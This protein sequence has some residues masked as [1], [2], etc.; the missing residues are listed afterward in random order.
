MRKIVFLS[1][2]INLSSFIGFGQISF[3]K[4]MTDNG[5]D[6]GQGIVQLEDSS[7]IVTGSSSSFIEGPSQAFLLKLDSL[8]NFLWSAHYGGSES[9]WGRRVLNWNDSIFYVTGHSNSSGTGSYNFYLIK[10]DK[11]GNQLLDKHYERDGWDKMNDAAFSSD[12]TIFMVG[13]TTGTT[14]GNSDFYIVKT[15]KDG[16]TLWTKSFGT[17]GDDA[18]NSIKQYDDTTFYCVGKIFNTDS[19]LTKAAVLKLHADGTVIWTKEFGENGNYELND[20]FF[21][22]PYLKAVGT[23][24]HPVDGD[25][26]EYLLSVGLTGVFDVEYNVHSNGDVTYDNVTQYGSSGKIYIASFYKNDFSSGQSFDVGITRFTESLNWDVA[27]VNIGFGL[28]DRSGEIIPTNDGGA[29]SVGYVSGDDLGGSGVYVIKIGPNDAF[30]A[31][32]PNNVSG[33]VT[34][35]EIDFEVDQLIVFP[36]PSNGN[37]T[38][39]T[40]EE[41]LVNIVDMNGKQVHSDSFSEFTEISTL[42]W[43]KGIY[44]LK[45]QTQQ[46]KAGTLKLVVQ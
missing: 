5:Y 15:N 14:N 12:S 2:L 25:N 27:Y 4:V 37:I 40:N 32:D 38:I 23:R 24:I 13:E 11:D 41:T 3:F 8:G 29:V 39:K 31:V 17:A 34:I 7:Y 26:D 19:T 21:V 44:V 35:P 10:T 46:G 45:F 33:L 9:D 36:N 18:L 1:I 6:F 16:D 42:D 28:E 43:Q 20:L 22:G 30:P